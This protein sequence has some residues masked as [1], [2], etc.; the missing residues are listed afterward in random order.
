M[1]DSHTA[2]AVHSGSS[3][4]PSSSPQARTFNADIRASMPSSLDD[5][6]VYAV[7]VAAVAAAAAA[8]A[9]A[10]PPAPDRDPLPLM[11]WCLWII[12]LLLTRRRGTRGHAKWPWVN[13]RKTYHT[14]RNAA[15]TKGTIVERPI[16]KMK[17]SYRFGSRMLM[18]CST[19]IVRTW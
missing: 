6:C 15:G 3:S 2:A 7:A 19:S 1:E 11:L 13:H 12:F 8:A 18:A 4:S 16:V 5:M 10:P 9:L 17:Y 14:L